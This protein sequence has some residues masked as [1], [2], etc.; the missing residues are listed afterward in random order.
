MLLLLAT[1]VQ[2]QVRTDEALSRLSSLSRDSG[3]EVV[4]P[5]E[6]SGRNSLDTETLWTEDFE[7]G[8]NGWTIGGSTS[9]KWGL[10]NCY[11]CYTPS[12]ALWCAGVGEAAC[13]QYANNMNTYAI[14]P[15]ISLANHLNA[16]CSW[17]FKLRSESGRDYLRTYYSPDGVT[18]LA[19]PHHAVES[20]DPSSPAHYFWWLQTTINVPAGWPAVYLKWVFTSNGSNSGFEGAALD[21]ISIVADAASIH[22]SSPN[23]GEQ[24]AMGS[25]HSITWSTSNLPSG[26]NVRIEISR[27]GGVNWSTLS[28][29]A[30][31]NGSYP[32][33]P[34]SGDVGA[35]LRIRVSGV[36]NTQIS[37]VS[38]NNFSVCNPTPTVVAPTASTIWCG[39]SPQVVQWTRAACPSCDNVKIEIKLPYTTGAWQTLAASTANDNSEQI[40]LPV[41][42]SNAQAQLRITCTD[43]STLSSVSGVFAIAASTIT[44]IA[45]NGGESWAM[46]CPQTISWNSNCVTGNVG[47]YLSRN[48]AY[49]PFEAIAANVPNTGSYAWTPTG[50]ATSQACIRICS[51][52]APTICDNSNAVFTLRQPTLTLVVP[53][54]AETWCMGTAQTIRWT[55][56]GMTGNVKIELNRGY[57]SGAWETLVTNTA[58]DGSE[59]WSVGGAATIHARIRIIGLDCPFPGDTSNADFTISSPA[60]AVSSPHGGEVWSAGENRPITWT[61]SCITGNVKIE[62]NRSYPSGIWEMIASNALNTGNSSWTVTG[63]STTHA[64]IRVSSLTLPAT[65]D[66]SNSDFT[67]VSPQIHVLQPDG[68]ESWC[69]GQLDTIK[70]IASGLSAGENVKI[71]LGTVWSASPLSILWSTTSWTVP[72]TG[73]YVWT[74]PVLSTSSYAARIRISGV[75][76]TAAKDTSD[77]NFAI[78]KVPDVPPQV[79]IIAPIAGATWTI[80]SIGRVSWTTRGLC[81]NVT[82]QLQ[83]QT[84]GAIETIGVSVPDTG[85]FDWPVSGAVTNSAVVTVRGVNNTAT[86]KTSY[87]FRIVSGGPSASPDGRESTIAPSPTLAVPSQFFVQQNYPNPF[88]P[89]TTIEFGVPATTHITLRVFDILGREVDRLVEGEVTAGIHRVTWNCANC[90]NGVYLVVMSG[91]GFSIVR[92]ATFMK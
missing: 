22:V 58:N 29:S 46:S 16:Q 3:T 40:T 52:N 53:N 17:S 34:G 44:V 59:L 87:V 30:A 28:L 25:A 33:T 54:G 18:W 13:S 20:G 62:L 21:D 35:A 48:G 10:V 81:E 70:W 80:G 92:K 82:I 84:N 79:G 7:S 76:H 37:D 85:M 56:A 1:L 31:N 12:H 45:P 51:V 23:G 39:G 36:T 83:R 50:L 60:I 57:P 74:V 72:N 73:S 5:D 27:D 11:R 77:R 42:S 19:S 63:P 8:A 75:T 2:G 68:G 69:Q 89:S 71:E 90:A 86:Y 9:V 64:R 61:Y 32:W 88:N 55:P 66:T 38:D 15:L 24:W 41:V 4:P 67:I 65:S 26:E 14:T 91:D 6:P 43:N 49:G 47:I 78:H